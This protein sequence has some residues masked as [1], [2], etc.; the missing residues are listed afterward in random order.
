MTQ[1][2]INKRMEKHIMVF[3]Y[4]VYFQKP[5][6]SPPY[7]GV[8]DNNH[9]EF[10]EAKNKQVLIYLRRSREA[11][12]SGKCTFMVNGIRTCSDQAV[13]VQNGHRGCRPIKKK[14]ITIICY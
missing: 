3:S 2:F 13:K 12:G 1:M 4:K 5:L 14:K 10:R 11:G 7:I 8:T 6:F 9:S